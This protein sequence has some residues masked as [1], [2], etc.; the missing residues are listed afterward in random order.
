VSLIT[1]TPQVTVVVPTYRRP[2]MLAEALESILNGSYSDFEVLVA[3]DGPEADLAVARAK[4]PDPRVTWLTRPDRL[5]MLA[6]HVDAFRRA[7]G[8]FIASL[9]DDDRWAPDLLSTLVPVLEHHA[10]VSVAFADHFVVNADGVIDET[11]TDANSRRW[12]RAALTEGPHRPFLKLAVVDRSIPM[13]CA[14]LFRR[15][16][17]NLDDYPEPVGMCWD[18]WTAY[19]L[20]RGGGTAWYV[21]KRLA[22]YRLH[23]GS[24]TAASRALNARAAIYCCERFLAGDELTAW[25]GNLKSWLVAAHARL[26]TDLFRAGRRREGCWHARRASELVCGSPLSFVRA[27]IRRRK[28]PK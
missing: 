12:G 24:S 26:A 18:V 14:A 11:R 22:F 21:P 27:V 25:R 17:L 20:A 2:H 3:N 4:F 1:R 13:Q 7:R 6:N 8:E 5:G 9:D 28:S 16:A 23:A 15:G 10:D 19:L